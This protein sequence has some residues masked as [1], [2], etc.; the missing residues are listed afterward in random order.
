MW[1]SYEVEK[2]PLPK[3]ESSVGID[4]GVR[5]AVL[6]TGERIERKDGTGRGCL[7]VQEDFQDQTEAR[8]AISARPGIVMP[9]ILSSRIIRE[10]ADR[11]GEAEHPRDGNEGLEE[12][13]ADSRNNNPGGFC[14]IKSYKAEWARRSESRIY[15]A[16][17]PPVRRPPRSKPSGQGLRRQGPQ[18]RPEHSQAGVLALGP[19][20]ISLGKAWCQNCMPHVYKPH[21]LQPGRHFIADRS[22]VWGL[23]PARDRPFDLGK[24]PIGS[25]RPRIIQ[26]PS[27]DDVKAPCHERLKTNNGNCVFV[28]EGNPDPQSPQ[29]L[30]RI[31]HQRARPAQS[32]PEKPW[33]IPRK[34]SKTDY[35]S[36]YA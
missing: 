12:A 36:S 3:C 23:C 7:Q 13:G 14:G 32:V 26:D 16:G 11:C 22:P 21:C 25:R 34:C 5:Q 15:I 24:R 8:T 10:H 29:Q 35:F 27:C 1:T 6:S 4:L 28:V 9:A 33:K 18:C 19:E 30:A 20:R 31:S 17:L 2:P